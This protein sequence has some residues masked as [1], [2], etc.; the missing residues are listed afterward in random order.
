MG[1]NIL[2]QYISYV[3]EKYET[4]QRVKRIVDSMHTFFA[5]TVNPDGYHACTRENIKKLDLNRNLYA[6]IARGALFYFSLESPDRH[7]N[8]S[9]YT[10]RARETINLMNWIAHSETKFLLST[11]YHGG[12]ESIDWR[13]TTGLCNLTLRRLCGELPI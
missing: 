6:Q 8:G 10:N 3:L 9:Y 7:R 13:L 5:L 11:N 1:T 4:D 2:I 12:V